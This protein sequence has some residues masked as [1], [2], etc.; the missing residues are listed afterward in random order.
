[1]EK[2]IHWAGNGGPTGAALKPES[3]DTPYLSGGSRVILGREAN[4]SQDLTMGIRTI[5]PG[6]R[7]AVHRH[8]RA[9]QVY[10][11]MAGVALF[12]VGEDEVECREGD[13]VYLPPNC[14]HGVTV[15]NDKPATVMW[16]YNKPDRDAAGSELGE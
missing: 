13:A 15:R 16:A 1:M 9:S 6:Q 5:E 14:R 3:A 11:V 10:F 2:V 12:T 4:G 7:V 8:S